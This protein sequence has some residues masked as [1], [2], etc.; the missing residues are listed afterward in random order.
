MPDTSSIRGLMLVALLLCTGALSSPVLAET[1]E[2]QSTASASEELSKIISGE[3]K[4]EK[5]TA[6]EPASG[7]GDPMR[8]V[9]PNDLQVNAI[10][11]EKYQISMQAYY[12][13]RIAGLEHRRKVFKWQLFSAKLIFIVVL[14]LVA[15][16]IYFAAVQ[17]H[18]GLR[19]GGKQED[20]PQTEFEA[21]LKGI[22]VRSPILGVIILSLSLAFFYL[23]LIYV[24]PIED[25]F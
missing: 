12:D 11:L 2:T 21:S 7:D 14:V 4:L 10:T 17:F 18:S 24:Y 19:L 15:A 5:R 16:G 9:E 20:I 6:P 1:D 25:V 8:P 13:Y 3:I 22:K 23:Y